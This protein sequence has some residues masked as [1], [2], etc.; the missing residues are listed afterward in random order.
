MAVH[1]MA[2]LARGLDYASGDGGSPTI[3]TSPG[4]ESAAVGAGERD[5]GSGSGGHDHL[6]KVRRI[7]L[8]APRNWLA[9]GRRER[10]RVSL[11][12]GVVTVPLT[13]HATG[14]AWRALVQRPR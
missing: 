3:L 8:D 11:A 2:H 4:S 1:N 13:G 6:P 9:A 10:R 14:H 5:G 12:C 7:E